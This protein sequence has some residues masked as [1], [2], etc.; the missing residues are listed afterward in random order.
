M[1]SSIT[2]NMHG[3][4]EGQ[5]FVSIDQVLVTDGIQRTL[6]EI[7]TRMLNDAGLKYDLHLMV[8]IGREENWRGQEKSRFG[9]DA[10]GRSEQKSLQTADIEDVAR[11]KADLAQNHKCRD[12]KNLL[13]PD[14]LVFETWN[15]T[16]DIYRNMKK[17]AL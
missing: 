17:Y 13:K 15:A 4:G 7:V 8:V 1:A 2:I 11:Q 3:Q 16:P 10:E 12:I 6:A 5:N 9:T 14:K